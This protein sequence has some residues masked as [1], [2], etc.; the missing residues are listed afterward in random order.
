MALGHLTCAQRYLF[1]LLTFNI[2]SRNYCYWRMYFWQLILYPL[3]NIWL[4]VAFHCQRMCVL[5]SFSFILESSTL[6]PR[7]LYQEFCWNHNWTLSCLILISHFFSSVGLNSVCI[8]LFVNTRYFINVFFV[9]KLNRRHR[10]LK[11]RLCKCGF[12]SV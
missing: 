10:F 1:Y 7:V 2:V 6:W 4:F 8:E 3:V 11:H 9:Y 5:L 12:C